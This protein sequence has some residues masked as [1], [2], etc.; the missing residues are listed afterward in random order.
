MNNPSWISQGT[1]PSLNGLRAVSI[2]LVIVGHLSLNPASAL[3]WLP[4]AA[5]M[6]VE[7]FFVISGFLITLLLE[8]EQ[9][10]TH[11]ISLKQ[12]YIRRCLRIVPA[13]ALFLLVMFL[14]QQTGRNSIPPKAWF[15][16]LT[17]TSSIFSADS[18]DLGHTWSLSVEEHF[19]L[20][21]PFLFL[22]LGKKRAFLA[23]VACIA[24]SPF[25]RVLLGHFYFRHYGGIGVSMFTLC[26]M[27]CLAVG[28]CLAMLAS[29][30]AGRRYLW[31]EDRHFVALCVGATAL[32]AGSRA[33]IMYFS[34]YKWASHCLWYVAP[35]TDSLLMAAVIWG[36]VNAQGS[37][38]YRVLNWR[39]LAGIGVLSYGIY[40]WQQ[41]LTSPHRTGG[42]FSFPWNVCLVVVLAA[43]SYI[44]VEAPCLNLKRKFSEARLPLAPRGA[45]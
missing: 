9:R 22:A 28:C 35:T 30:Q 6:G 39:P 21:W 20:V 10:R 18:F 31:L 36:T 24:V 40:L 34:H 38:A 33:C 15:C 16:A 27:D 44:L 17:Y 12:F 26:R 1:I 2:V 8:R 19:Y 3:A 29:S 37:L 5:D 13:Y 25:L 4:N 32:L 7:M 11:S 45:Q 41:P 23:C 42:M 43:L 14:I